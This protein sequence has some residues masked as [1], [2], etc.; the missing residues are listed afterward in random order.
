M[1]LM[2]SSSLHAASNATEAAQ[3]AIDNNPQVQALYHAFAASGD[4]RREAWGGYLPSIDLNLRGGREY[5]ERD[6]RGSFTT[7][8]A[9]IQ[10]TQMLYDG[11]FT[12]SEVERLDKA[13][14][15]RYYELLDG[16][17]DVALEAMRAYEDVVR[18]QTLVELARDNY[19]RHREVFD[20]IE[21]RTRTGVGRG[22]DLEQISGR[23]ALAESNLLT[24]ASNLHDVTARYQRIVGELPQDNLE[25][26]ELDGSSIPEDV[27]DVLT[28]AYE[29]NPG[30]HAAIENISSAQANV[31][32]QRSAFHPRLDLQ[33]RQST[34]RNAEPFLGTGDRDITGDRGVVELV[35]SFNLF[36]GG[37]DRAAV[38]RA[39]NE[40]FEAMDLR[41]QACIDLRQ[42]AQV[43]F[44]D[45]RRLAQ[46]KDALNQHR[47]SVEKVRVAFKEQFDIGQR[48]LLDVL[49]TENEFFQASRAYV[50]AIHDQTIAEGRVL[51]AMGRLLPALDLSQDP[52]LLPGLEQVG[53]DPVVPDG[54]SVCPPD[55]VGYMDLDQLTADLEQMR[56]R[57][58]DVVLA[59]D[60]LFQINSAELMDQFQEDLDRLADQLQRM[61]NLERVL[62][63]GHADST[64]TDAIND[65]LSEARAQ[66]VKDFLV[67]RGVPADRIH[68]EGR[69]SR[70]PVASNDNPRGRSQNRRVE[71][72]IDGE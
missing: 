30:F 51:D 40:L 46:Q 17:S 20:Q 60:T 2:L 41:D 35:L 56:E 64:G 47:L 53:A 1:G 39:T 12:R 21:E 7:G 8:T 34:N 55:E 57:E 37:S 4:E 19:A 5:R 13:R 72:T 58:P 11:F 14:L 3:R 48:T 16:A 69:G 71:I 29:G 32:T 25:R 63:V 52:A 23:L 38:S 18:Q 28:M 15:V 9:E 59:S 24:E 26:T 67:E 31:S 54:D 65:P 49:D 42:D 68:T 50:N 43:A 45:R 10:L 33:A 6:N 27:R 66:S 61:G 22:V 62:I 36:R 70:D 44:N